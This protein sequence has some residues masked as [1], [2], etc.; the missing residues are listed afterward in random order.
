MKKI[1]QP[2]HVHS[3]KPQKFKGSGY[4]FIYKK[5]T[6][7]KPGTVLYIITAPLTLKFHTQ[8]THIP[9]PTLTDPLLRI[10]QQ[11]GNSR[12]AEYTIYL[13]KHPKRSQDITEKNNL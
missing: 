13:K 3:S 10:F 8:S 6:M 4:N 5:S 9:Y 12:G 7:R 11:R 1:N 2:E